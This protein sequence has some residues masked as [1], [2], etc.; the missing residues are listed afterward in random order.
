MPEKNSA[1]QD[2]ACADTAQQTAELQTP[3]IDPP[4]FMFQPVKRHTAETS[5]RDAGAKVTTII[6]PVGY[7]KTVLISEMLSELRKAGRQCLWLALDDRDQTIE[8]VLSALE[9]LLNTHQTNRHPTHAL[10]RGQESLEDRYS[11][12]IG[13]LNSDSHPTT[14]FIDNLNYC[15]DAALEQLLN[16]L[17]FKTTPAL[18]LVLSSTRELPLDISRAQLQGLICQLGPAELS[19][20]A[21][22][23]SALL[24]PELCRQIGADG[25]NDITRQTE[26]WPAAVRMVQIILS[27]ARQ[28]LAALK[29]F[30]GSDEALAHFLNHQVLA[31]FPAKVRD[32]LLCIAQLRSFC[33]ELCSYVMKDNQAKDN[34]SEQLAYLLARNVFVIPLDR[35]RSWYRLHGLFREHL[36]HE[37]GKTLTLARRQEVLTRAADWCEKNGYWREAIDYAFTSGATARIC[38]ILEHRAPIMVRKLGQIS[39]Y[40]ALIDTLHEQGQQ[41]G[42]EAE[43]WFVWAL[44]FQRRYDQA[45]RQNALLMARVQRHQSRANDAGVSNLQRRGAILQASLD[46][47]SDH[48][49]EAYRGASLWLNSKDGS[50]DPFNLTAANCIKSCFYSNSQRFVEARQAI[51][52]AQETAFQATS[53]YVDGWTS[54]YSALIPIYEGNYAAAY[55]ELSPSLTVTRTTLGEDLGIAGTMAMVAA[56]CAAEMGLSEEAWQL[57]EFGIKTSRAHGFLETAACGLEAAVLLWDGSKDSRISISYLREVAS[58][59]PPRL[60]LML[61]CY[62]IRRL[63]VLGRA[64][65]AYDEAK[66]TGLKVGQQAPQR[67]P[68]TDQE[69]DNLA[70]TDALIE[71]THIAMLI[72]RARYEPAG[73][74]VEAATRRAKAANCA[75]RLVDLALAAAT[76]AVR[77][78]QPAAAVRHITRAVNIAAR[79]AIVRPFNDY[80]ETLRVVVADTKVHAW[81]FALQEERRFFAERCRSL[82][83]AD[84]KLYDKLAALHNEE[85]QLLAR[86]TARELELLGYID[87]GLTNQQIADRIDVA[88]TTVKW[89]LQ[90]LFAKLDSANRTAALAKARALNLMPGSR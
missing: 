16:Q 70:H 62:L 49:Q 44:V 8:S 86:L 2:I 75:A 15:N 30:S 68:K 88:L 31:G 35:N 36:L 34:S 38:R 4:V 53:A 52:A 42:L 85:P 71:D 50:D 21:A 83:F 64:S 66:R 58:V 6:A 60:A 72:A 90:N 80:A 13:Q 41:A 32:F 18:Q 39:E 9:L 63:L 1:A 14:L 56:K 89:H 55:A 17:S 73:Q 74:M 69:R 76:I 12:L 65:E 46:T 11:L 7:G 28:P 19:F 54:I 48:L 33:P 29:A 45:R 77:T 22:D 10:F 25:I 47:L 57:V 59:Y 37:A 3:R 82:R 20:N 87:A 78:N 84:I 61:S 79:H 43:Y 5:A 24:G 26:G 27:N 51:Q 67:A 40:I 81:G 23:V